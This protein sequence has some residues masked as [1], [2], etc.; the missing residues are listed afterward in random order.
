LD[1]RR[2]SIARP[3][4]GRPPA[5]S[6]AVIIAAR[7]EALQKDLEKDSLTST[8]DL[9]GMVYRQMANEDEMQG[10]NPLA[11]Q[12]PL[13]AST[14]RKLVKRIAPVHVRNGGV[15][16]S[17]RRR[18][19]KDSRN[20]IS[21]A[22]TWPAVAG[23]ITNPKFIHSW[24][25]C[26]VMLNAFDEKQDLLCTEEGR[27]ILEEE[28]LT[29]AT[30]ETQGQRRMFKIALSKFRITSYIIYRTHETKYTRKIIQTQALMELWSALSE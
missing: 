29:P 14:Q 4:S 28:N 24:D 20:A 1:S 8:G 22:A 3:P 7:A 23:G 25:E 2:I 19:L 11:R 12:R 27:K 17:S 16:N 15:Q 5:V 9:M 30:T 26:S 18:A 6:E 10:R 21:C 13:S